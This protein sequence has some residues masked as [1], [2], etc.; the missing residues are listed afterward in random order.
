MIGYL[1][2]GKWGPIGNPGLYYNYVLA[3]NGLFVE[4]ES[5]LLR[6]SVL[7]AGAEVRGLAPKKEGVELVNGRIPR[8]LFDLAISTLLSNWRLERYLAIVWDN[9]YRVRDTSIMADKC[10]VRYCNLPS[11]VM[12]IHSHG[13]MGA[14]FSDTDD[15]DEQG[16]RLSMVVGRL[17]TPTPEISIRVGIYGYFKNVEFEEVFA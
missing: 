9:G 10:S 11:T 15:R 1:I 8:H 16:L 3:G 12:D 5:P 4:T 6:A 7:I 13:S 14:Y 17:N 2:N